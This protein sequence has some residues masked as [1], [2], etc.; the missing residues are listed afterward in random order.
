MLEIS[1]IK[2]NYTSFS[3]QASLQL[4]PGKIYGLIGPNGAG[5]VL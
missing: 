4:K 2:K 5:K 3:L 1:Q